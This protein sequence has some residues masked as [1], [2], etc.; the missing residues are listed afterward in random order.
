MA[1]GVV[2]DIMHEGIV[3]CAPHLS[4][5]EAAR[6]MTKANVRALVVVESNCGLT[7]IVSTTDLVNATLDRPATDGKRD[8]TVRDVMTTP[9]LTVTPD[10]PIAQAAKLMLD[11][12]VHRLVVVENENENCTPIGILSMGDI[13]RSI[14]EE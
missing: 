13:V 6:L 4:L 7:G 2:R 9:V 11:R 3:S 14:S 10:A 5:K 8:L 1:A 12:N